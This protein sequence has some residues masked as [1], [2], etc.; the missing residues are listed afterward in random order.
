[1][2]S[3]ST[4]AGIQSN[5][6]LRATEEYVSKFPI[7]DN[8][9]VFRF[10]QQ[11]LKAD[12]KSE[13]TRISYEHI[14]AMLL[15]QMNKHVS[16]I[17]YDDVSLFKESFKVGKKASTINHMLTVLS[18]F[19][20]FCYEENFTNRFPLKLK[21]WRP[22]VPDS[23]P[24]YLTDNEVATAR[25]TVSNVHYSHRKGIDYKY[26]EQRDR[27]IF[28]LLI[29]SGM[30]ISE[31]VQ[32]NVEDVDIQ[33]RSVIIRKSKGKRERIVHFSE[34]CKFLLMEFIGNSPREAPLFLNYKKTRISRRKASEI[35]RKIGRLIQLNRSFSPHV[36]RH[37]FATRM[38]KKGAELTFVQDELGHRDPS[39]TQIYARLPDE[40]VIE[41]YKKCMG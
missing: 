5:K 2:L 7:K 13:N 38:L 36:C 40:Q 1:M 31:L 26:L 25:I 32:L 23:T 18:V 27:V 6:R 24:K 15:S 34:E 29:T 3:I 28:E 22:S 39:T 20:R 12:G 41:M 21:R 11:T 19:F 10:F 30:R 17:D 8:E 33:E 37:T 4:Q 9:S 35:I 14:I 16:E